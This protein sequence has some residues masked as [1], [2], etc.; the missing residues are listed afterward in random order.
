MCQGFNHFSFFCIIFVLAKLATSSIRVNGSRWLCM[1]YITVRVIIGMNWFKFV[2]A[3][4]G[5]YLEWLSWGDWC[6]FYMWD[7]CFALLQLGET[8]SKHSLTSL[9]FASFTTCRGWSWERRKGGQDHP[10]PLINPQN[11]EIHAKFPWFW[12]MLHL[13]ILQHAVVDHEREK[14]TKCSRIF[15]YDFFGLNN[16]I[17]S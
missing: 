15:N 11:D 4:P 2:P 3:C 1:K 5:E 10:P 14:G 12:N 6:T 8:G 7:G 13:I 16:Q 17:L 9:S